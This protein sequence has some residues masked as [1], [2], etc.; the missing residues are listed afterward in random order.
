MKTFEIVR[1]VDKNEEKEYLKISFQIEEDMELV[2]I[3]Y[4]Y[5]RYSDG[6]EINCID[7]AL[8]DGNGILLGA[9]GS[10]R[11]HFSFSEKY[12]SEGFL[13]QGL[14][15]G[16]YTIILG[17]YKVALQGVKV[18]YTFTFVEKKKQLL[19]GDLH[20][21][22]TASDG[23]NTI[24]QL[25]DLA[26][27]QGLDFIFVSDHNAYTQNQVIVNQPKVAVYPGS[28][29]TLYRG[30]F[31]VLGKEAGKKHPFSIHSEKDLNL[32]FQELEQD[33]LIIANHPSCDYC[34]IDFDLQQVNT[35]AWELYN[36]GTTKDANERI[37]AT[38]HDALCNGKKIVALGGSDFHS[39]E[40]FHTLGMP[41][42]GVYSESNELH[43]VLRALKKGNSFITLGKKGATIQMSSGTS[44]MGDTIQ[45]GEEVIISCKG[46]NSYDR[47]TIITDLTKEL[48]QDVKTKSFEFSIKITKEKF[49]RVEIERYIPYTNQYMRILISNPIYIDGEEGNYE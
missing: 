6:V 44:M 31:G 28:E 2:E 36:G 41:C 38:W 49:V 1:N 23:K 43:D 22:S 5:E 47:I 13:K 42:N 12:T 40:P 26:L 27:G 37:L 3:E 46:I 8:V 35:H 25:A 30:H 18:T 48:F 19:F 11:S 14:K 7:F 15:K 4:A 29:L 34:K 32:Y 21:H 20:L 45:V 10:N 16:N 9:A 17:A 33:H 24:H 39:H